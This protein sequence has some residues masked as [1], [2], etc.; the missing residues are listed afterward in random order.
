M[1]LGVKNDEKK[2]AKEKIQDILTERKNGCIV[3]L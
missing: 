1:V 2:K 3:Y